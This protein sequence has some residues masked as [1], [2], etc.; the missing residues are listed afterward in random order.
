MISRSGLLAPLGMIEVA[1]MLGFPPPMQLVGQ[2]S[3][4][5]LLLEDVGRSGVYLL[6]FAGGTFYI[7]LATDVVRR[8]A[9]HRRAHG[10]RVLAFAFLPTHRSD[11]T[12]SRSNRR[13]GSRRSTGSAL[14]TISSPK[15]TSSGGNATH[16]VASLTCRGSLHR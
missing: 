5:G 3:I 1:R 7:G 4:A 16:P 14:W 12:A 15:R 9:Q 8:F 2:Q 13:S 10:D 6:G 11:L